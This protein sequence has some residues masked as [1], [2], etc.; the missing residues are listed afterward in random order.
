VFR[1][2]ERELAGGQF[3][4]ATLTQPILGKSDASQ[5]L[6]SCNRSR[7]FSRRPSENDGLDLLLYLGRPGEIT[8]GLQARRV[9]MT[10]NVAMSPRSI[11]FQPDQAGHVTSCADGVCE[12]FLFWA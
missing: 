9:E 4:F 11:D 10:S 5:G 3:R 7:P 1:L 12:K 8:N 2:D 6:G